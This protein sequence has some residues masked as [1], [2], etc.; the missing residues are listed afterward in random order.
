[1]KRVILVHGWSGSPTEHW[2]PWIKS[3][4]EKKGYNVDAPFM[5]THNEPVIEEW[6]SHLEE[7]AGNYDENT[8]FVGHSIGCQAILRFI[9]K[10]GK[11][12]RGAV[13]VAGW[14]DLENMETLEEE[15]IARPWIETSVD[16]E[17]MRE[18]LPKSSLIISDND[19]Y[20]A[21]EFNKMKFAELGSKIVV[22]H[23][24]GHLT[25]EDGFNK[26]PEVL[27]EIE[28]F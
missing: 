5:R 23:N 1:M 2:F 12:A 8:V 3:E 24:A 27:E 6:I 26:L 21:F 14:F 15:V 28:R 18:L 20:G 11:K 16:L 19:P 9:E 10:A 4:L 7:M 17:R 13:F 25:S 22:I